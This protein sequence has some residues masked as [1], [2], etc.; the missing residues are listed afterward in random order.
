MAHPL[1]VLCMAIEHELERGNYLLVD[2]R[3][4]E[5]DGSVPVAK[6]GCLQIW[7]NEIPWVFHVFQTF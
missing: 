7:Q 6:T 1:D 4:P 2:S 3:Y 5:A